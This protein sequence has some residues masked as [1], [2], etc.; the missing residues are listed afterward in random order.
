VSDSVGILIFA[1]ATVRDGA[2]FA[3]VGAVHFQSRE[4]EAL[5]SNKRGKKAAVG[6]THAL[7]LARKQ[8]ML[9]QASGFGILFL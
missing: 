4:D 8:F 7:V 3:G 1:V 6:M 9:Q 5:A 2:V